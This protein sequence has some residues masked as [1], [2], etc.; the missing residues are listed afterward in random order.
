MFL[1]FRQ[2]LLVFWVVRRLSDAQW[3][4]FLPYSWLR[5]TLCHERRRKHGRFGHFGPGSKSLKLSEC[6]QPDYF[7]RFI[8]VLIT[9]HCDLTLSLGKIYQF[10]IVIPC[11]QSKLRATCF[12]LSKVYFRF[13]ASGRSKLTNYGRLITRRSATTSRMGTFWNNKEGKG[14]KRF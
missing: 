4:L 8:Q 11:F 2:L 1:H 12:I 3:P 10:Y 14:G 13:S 9:G 6:S 7:S 5:P